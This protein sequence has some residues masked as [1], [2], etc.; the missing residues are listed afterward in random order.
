[1]T[2]PIAQRAREFAEKAHGD[3]TRKYTGH[4]Y[5]EHLYDVAL[6][7]FTHNQHPFTIAAGWLHDVLED[8]AVTK[9]ELS[10]EFG[11]AVTQLVW[12][13]TD[14]SKPRDGN[15][16]ARKAID[17]R[18]L[19]KS[20]KEGAAI[21][22]ADLISNSRDIVKHDPSFARVYLAEKALLLPVL[23][24]GPA[25]LYA[26]ATETLENSLKLMGAE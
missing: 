6:L 9:P 20:S 17:R 25:D 15:R 11:R 13:V 8:T 5:T 7:L 19:A 18:W 14:Q 12:E 16:A 24:H 2:T 3:Q 21:K 22:L 10:K 26:L 1:M 23:A 4:P